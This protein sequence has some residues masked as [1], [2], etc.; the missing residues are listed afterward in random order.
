MSDTLMPPKKESRLVELA[1]Q[2]LSNASD[3]LFRAR[4]AASRCD[5]NAQWGHSGQ[6]L[7]EIIA[8]YEEWERQALDALDFARKMAERV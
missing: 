6:T 2:D 4:L 7:G 8:G 3:N 5:V 1:M